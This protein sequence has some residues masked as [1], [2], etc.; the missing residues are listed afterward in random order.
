[1]PSKWHHPKNDGWSDI[2]YDFGLPAPERTALTSSLNDACHVFRLHADGNWVS[3]NKDRYARELATHISAHPGLP[4][5]LLRS[6]DRVIAM[7]THRA[8]DRATRECDAGRLTRRCSRRAT[9]LGW[10]S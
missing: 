2:D 7:L 3:T 1:M 5:R 8:I 10:E 9:T 4:H 6:G